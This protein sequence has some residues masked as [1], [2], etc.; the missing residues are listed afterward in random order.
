MHLTGSDRNT[1]A[2]ADLF[3]NPDE[4]I[5][6]EHRLNDNE[7][8]THLTFDAAPNSGFYAIKEKQS[9]DWPLVMAAVGL[10]LSANKTRIAKARICAGAVAP[11]P[12]PLPNV[13]K[14]LVGLNPDDDTAIKN[15]CALAAN[16]AQ[17][18]TQNAY[19]T[20]LLP[21]AIHRALRK[22]AGLTVEDLNQ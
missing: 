8:I 9:S 5:R 21:V 11:M 14:A 1:I 2:I 7:I 6:S 22:A 4:Q 20:K 3:H 10:T 18:M 16:G 15:A 17:P 13:E 19:K 12:Y